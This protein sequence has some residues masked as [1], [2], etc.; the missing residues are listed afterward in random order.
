[1][2]ENL[3]PSS[4]CPN[5]VRLWF[6]FLVLWLKIWLLLNRRRR[7]KRFQN[8]GKKYVVRASMGH[9]R[10]L[11]KSKMGIDVEHDFEPVYMVPADKKKLLPN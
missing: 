5:N 7:R 4:L 10:D 11:P 6:I 2:V 3:T 1:M 9:V 8:A